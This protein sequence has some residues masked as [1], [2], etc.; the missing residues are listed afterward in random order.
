MLDG[1]P[2]WYI[3]LNIAFIEKLQIQHFF[4]QEKKGKSVQTLSFFNEEVNIVLE[5]KMV[6]KVL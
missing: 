5:I 4:F 3:Y 2:V 1:Q 6:P